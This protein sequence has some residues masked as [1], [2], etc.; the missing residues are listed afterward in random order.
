MPKFW[1]KT[2][3]TGNKIATDLHEIVA[4]LISEHMKKP[5]ES[6]NVTVLPGLWMS[7]GGTEEPCAV[8]NLTSI[9]DFTEDTC[10]RLSALLMLPV[11]KAL[12]LS[13][14]RMFLNFN[15]VT[16]GIMGFKGTTIKLLREK[17]E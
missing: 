5:R 2:N 9:Y 12:S 16:T 17:K 4:S 15:A 3:V 14:D 1:I 6:I 13:E 7:M 10:A 11:C 8:C